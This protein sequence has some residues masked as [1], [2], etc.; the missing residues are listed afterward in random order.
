MAVLEP[1]SEGTEL[2]DRLETGISQAYWCTLRPDG[3][4]DFALAKVSVGD[5]PA[6]E[7]SWF[8]R[9]FES[10]IALKKHGG[11]PL[12]MLLTGPPGSGK[13]TL[14]VEL[15]YRLA[16]SESQRRSSLY[17]ST[18]ANTDQ[19]IA[20]AGSFGFE[21]T[22]DYLV[23]FTGEP[24]PQ[25]VAVMGAEQLEAGAAQFGLSDL[26]SVVIEPAPDARSDDFDEFEPV[27]IDHDDPAEL[28]EAIILRGA[29]RLRALLTTLS[30]DVLVID[31]LNVLEP[32]RRARFFHRFLESAREGTKLAIFVLDSGERQP[33]FWEYVCDFVVRLDYSEQ[34][35]YF[36][37]TIEIVK[38]R[39]Q[40]HVLG[41]HH[42]KIYAPKQS[43]KPDRENGEDGEGSDTDEKRKA[44]EAQ[45]MRRDHPYRSEG[46][47]FIY[48]SI[49]YYLSLYKRLGSG[50]QAPPVA[51]L[52]ESLNA[53]L[54]EQG[55]G[56]LPEGRCTA[57]IGCRGG[58]KSHLGYLH[59]LHRVLTSENERGL[60]VSLRDDEGITRG[61]LQKILMGE[62]GP[63]QKRLAEE[64]DQRS[65]EDALASRA[66]GSPIDER[67]LP[68]LEAED[69]LEILYYHPG[70]ITPEEFVHRM[71]MSI[72]R[73]KSGRKKL[74][75]LF[76]SLDQLSSRFPL[77]SKQEIFVPG[78]IEM[79]SGEGATS[80]FIAVD[81]VGQPIEQYGLLPMSDLILAFFPHQFPFGE[82]YGHLSH[83]WDA[84][85]MDSAFWK[86]AMEIRDRET[87]SFREEIVLQVVRFAGGQ[88]AGR[89]GILELVREPDKTL[90]QQ[91]GL[92]FTALSPQVPSF[93]TYRGDPRLSSGD[94]SSRQL[95]LLL[96]TDGR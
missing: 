62:L 46:G 23:P 43:R 36:Q 27:P 40:S 13:T 33:Q 47:I 8:D 64:L 96:P 9:L 74:T 5:A 63:R 35:N 45:R 65:E 12:T 57:F 16:R 29:D 1:P 7:V 94:V 50:E 70:Y 76:N 21:A 84:D 80:I 3:T 34:N 41:K 75:V 52:P 59:L 4:A 88:Q 11:R 15:C 10:G 87:D 30:P 37:R 58:H 69:R 60:I 68:A 28:A 26:T 32:M 55:N 2:V 89:R 49:H 72:Q 19:I 91:P 56:G 44:A 85:R 25:T 61:T 22:N 86:R 48:P 90:Y 81:E 71:F 20:N 53:I 83:S 31:N 51:T 6:T 67:T 77:C 95:G 73:L 17:V 82:Y 66:Y 54:G 18:D 38:A 14:A 92:H 78:I 42:L 79:L 24:Q 39:Y 93:V